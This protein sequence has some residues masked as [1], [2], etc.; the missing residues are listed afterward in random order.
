MATN[1]DGEQK[2]RVIMTTDSEIDDKCSM[3]RFLVYTNCFDVEGIISVNSQWQQ[4]GHGEIWI[5][6]MIKQYAEVYESLAQ[7]DPAY[8]TPAELHQVT[9]QGMVDRAPI[10]ADAPPYR[11]TKGSDL[12]IEKLLDA[13]PRP[14]YISM[15]G[16]GTMV[17]HAFWKLKN[18]YPNSAFEQAVD[19]ARM[20]FIS[21]QEEGTGGGQW[22]RDE[23]PEAQNILD[24]QF[25][26]T[27]N[28]RPRSDQPYE[29]MMGK[30]WLQTNV[31]QNHG[32]LGSEYFWMG[33]DELY[34]SEGDTPSFLW[35]VNNG[36]R[37]HE[38][39]D[40]GGWGGRHRNLYANQWGDAADDG[41]EKKPMWRWI[42][43]VQNDWAARL[44][45]CVMSPEEANH[46][47]DVIVDGPLDRT[48]SPGE[49]VTVDASA[50]TDP[51]G[52]DLTF[53]WWQYTD[54]G[55]TEG[56]I[57]I[58]NPEAAT[59]EFDIPEEAGAE[60]HLICEVTDTGEPP[61]TRYQR[62]IFSIE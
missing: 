10:Y 56:T 55:T 29:D 11:D 30:A 18:E 2:Q 12:I 3:L 36:L 43:A 34:V 19:K 40:Y 52:N 53:S 24:Y 31:T 16:G 49:T 61:L 39:P 33:D 51:D 17:A 23:I 46:P 48:V 9:W 13:D 50:S 62:I 14:V 1:A 28:Y 44:D 47:P 60:L 5:H 20:Y 6:E 22:L 38:R 45:W 15:W 4:D 26:D 58:E 21:Y 27:W 37:S 54:A 32:P 8:P 25:V 35:I 42:P 7:H 59:V 57:A 41:D